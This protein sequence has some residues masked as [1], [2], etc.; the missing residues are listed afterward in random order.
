MN[1]HGRPTRTIWLDDDGATVVVIDQ[2][3]LP[4]ELRLG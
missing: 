3:R 1:V 4:H 2:T